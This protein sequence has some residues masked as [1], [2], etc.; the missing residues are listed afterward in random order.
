MDISK[1][2]YQGLGEKERAVASYAAINRDDQSEINRLNGHTSNDQTDG[3]IVLA[4][5]QALNVYNFLISE[6]IKNFLVATV[7]SQ[8]ASSFRA[9]WLAAGGATDNDAYQKIS[10]LAD[11]LTVTSGN[12][13]CEIEAV[14]QAAYTWCKKNDVPVSFFSGPLCIHPLREDQKLPEE[15][16]QKDIAGSL[17]MMTSAFDTVKMP[18]GSRPVL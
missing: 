16:E 18:R 11:A 8:G 9:G 14:R 7:K 6:A 2:I 1:K 10:E 17:E 13:A 12:M 4:L 5:Y 3:E 15:Y